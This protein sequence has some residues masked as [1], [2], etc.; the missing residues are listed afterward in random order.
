MGVRLDHSLCYLENTL[1]DSTLGECQWVD[2][3]MNPVQ[4]GA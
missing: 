2:H 4:H 3:Q 1:L